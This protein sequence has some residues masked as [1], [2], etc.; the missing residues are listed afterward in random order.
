[1]I[2][3]SFLAGSKMSCSW[4][5]VSSPGRAEWGA[6]RGWGP[7]ACFGRGC[8]DAACSPGG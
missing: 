3:S 1:M 4:C 6:S 7:S 2:I 5:S 8:P